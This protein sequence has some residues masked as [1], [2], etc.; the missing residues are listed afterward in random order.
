[1]KLSK[2]AVLGFIFFSIILFVLTYIMVSKNVKFNDIKSSVAIMVFDEDKNEYI[3]SSEI[4]KGNYILNK[5]KTKCISGGSVENYDSVNGTI[6]YF[7]DASDTCNLYFDIYLSPSQPS[8]SYFTLTIFYIDEYGNEISPKYNR[9]MVSGSSYNVA[10]PAIDGYTPNQAIVSGEL[11]S[12]VTISVV[13]L[14]DI[15]DPDVPI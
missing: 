4:P 13:Y 5:E 9:R 12:D 14:E 2:K 15:E 7:I 11:T 8:G 6:S 1:M 10:S 3:G